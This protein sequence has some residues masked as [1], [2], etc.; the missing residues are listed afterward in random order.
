[1]LTIAVNR[2][3]FKP[4]SLRCT[5]LKPSVAAGVSGVTPMKPYLLAFSLPLIA[6]LGCNS[7]WNPGDLIVGSNSAGPVSV[8]IDSG[9]FTALYGVEVGHPNPERSNSSKHTENLLLALFVIPPQDSAWRFAGGG[10]N[11]RPWYYRL[12]YHARWMFYPILK[13]TKPY[14]K[15]VISENMEIREFSWR[16]DGRD[17]IITIAGDKYPIIAGEF[18][19]VKLDKRWNPEVGIGEESFE[20]MNIPAETR[21]LVA[22]CLVTL[23]RGIAA[24]TNT[25]SNSG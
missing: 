24:L 2:N 3:G 11:A 16:F 4:V 5:N 15:G 20:K 9:A 21:E 23:N 18:V 12:F 6:L 25:C 19:V 22:R 1:M 7:E 10:S 14:K 13:F 17:R 8:K